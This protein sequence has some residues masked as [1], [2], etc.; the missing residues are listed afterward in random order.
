MFQK[1][2]VSKKVNML[3]DMD[4]S[5]NEY[6][7]D[8]S[9]TWLQR[10]LAEVAPNVSLQQLTDI[11]ERLAADLDGL[12]LAGEISWEMLSRALLEDSSGA[13]FVA[14]VLSLETNNERFAALVDSGT[15]DPD[16]ETGLADAV[17]W[18][19]PVTAGR[20]FATDRLDARPGWALLQ[21][22]ALASQRL[23]L[24]P[25]AG[26]ALDSLRGAAGRRLIRAAGELARCD[27]LPLLLER[28][29][30]TGSETRFQAAKSALLLGD[31][32][33]ALSAMCE[34]ACR[35]GPRQLRALQIAMLAAEPVSGHELLRELN[36]TP[37]AR[38]FRIIG[39]GYVGDAKYV[40]WLIEQMSIPTTA[41]IAA[42]AFVHI[43]GADFNLDQLESMPP[44]GFEDGPD[45]D[46]D[47]EDVEL[48]ED[49]SLPWPDVESIKAW[50]M[51]HRTQLASGQKLFL[52]KAISPEHC[53]H[54]LGTGYQR[55]RVIAAYYRSLN[56]PGTILFPT[57]A[58][59]WRQKRLLAAM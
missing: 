49:I 40:S 50:W 30:A 41:R 16:I 39:A 22:A 26:D 7:E 46:P 4:N 13:A 44:D 21:I 37:N 36:G 18:V 9:F 6:F 25:W 27:M 32:G 48:P 17:A 10:G 34:L 24:P 12:R 8:A 19:P 58:P 45:D 3:A 15:R 43:T 14:G 53:V 2:K 51:E 33:S 20:H 47:A 1:D 38:R 57:S 35:S 31:R 28:L 5:L 23:D 11:D 55:Q 29:K 52:G 42:E 59:A 54:V 56:E